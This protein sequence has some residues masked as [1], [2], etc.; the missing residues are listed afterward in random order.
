MI[1]RHPIDEIHDLRAE[2]RRLEQREAAL[3]RAVLKSGHLIGDA[4][5]GVVKHQVSERLD[6]PALRRAFGPVLRP[7]LRTRECDQLRIRKRR[8]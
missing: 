5:E 4:F 2:I 3:R 8:A 6:L 7:F 1:N